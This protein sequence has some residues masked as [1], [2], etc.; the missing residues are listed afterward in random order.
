MTF[1]C[2][3]KNKYI[4]WERTRSLM[5]GRP[6]EPL[7]RH[8]QRGAQYEAGHVREYQFVYRFAAQ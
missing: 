2:L 3:R 6:N 5:T 8:L 1:K 7:K 4:L